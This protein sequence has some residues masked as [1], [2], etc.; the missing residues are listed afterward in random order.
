MATLEDA[1]SD[2][3]IEAADTLCNEVKQAGRNSVTVHN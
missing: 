2:I 1:R 3:A